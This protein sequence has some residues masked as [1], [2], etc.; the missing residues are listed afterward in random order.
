MEIVVG[1]VGIEGMLGKGGWVTFG[2]VGKEGMFG[3][4][5]SGGRDPVLG[6]DGWV[7]SNVGTEGCGRVGRDGNGGSVALGGVDI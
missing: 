1:I 4:I 2:A 3:K 7:V 5:R 6:K